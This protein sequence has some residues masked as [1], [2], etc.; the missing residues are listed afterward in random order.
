MH[1]K[2]DT[3]RW[4]NGVILDVIDENEEHINLGKDVGISVGKRLSLD[5]FGADGLETNFD[6]PED[7][8]IFQESKPAELIPVLKS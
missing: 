1:R 7:F 8:K 4:D 2:I 6:K 3:E 5:D